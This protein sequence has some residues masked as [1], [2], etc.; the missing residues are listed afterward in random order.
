[1]RIVV[2][3]YRDIWRYTYRVGN[4]FS[5]TLNELFVVRKCLENKK[6]NGIILQWSELSEVGYIIW[7]NFSDNIFA[8]FLWWYEPVHHKNFIFKVSERFVYSVNKMI[9]AMFFFTFQVFKNWANYTITRP[10]GRQPRIQ[11]ARWRS[12]VILY[13][14]F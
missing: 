6:R 8:T 10:Q 7:L 9:L 11:D 1:M 13:T 14:I 3:E 5:D 2:H 12:K 4:K